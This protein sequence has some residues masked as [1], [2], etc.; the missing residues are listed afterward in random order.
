MKSTNLEIGGIYQTEWDKRPHRVIGLDGLEV[1][2]DSI[3]GDQSWIFSGNFRKKCYFYRTSSSIFENKSIKIDHAPLSSEEHTFFR[4]DL[5]MRFGRTKQ[6]N[7]N[8]INFESQSDLDHFAQSNFPKELVD[9]RIETNSIVVYPYGPAGG[10]KKGEKLNADNNISFSFPE[11]IWK[12][13]EI[14]ESINTNPSEG[15]GLYRI[16]IEKGLPSYYIGEYLDKA[17]LLK[18]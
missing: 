14:Q 15:L 7:W 5:V 13:K 2:Y 8:Q 11:L 18:D 10:L 6:L 1:F 12:C 9:Q 16:G 17:G 4:P 3:S